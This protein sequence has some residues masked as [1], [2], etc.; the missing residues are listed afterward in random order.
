MS[1]DLKQTEPVWDELDRRVW[2]RVNAPANMWYFFQALQQE[3]GGGGKGEGI[4]AQAIHK[5]IQ[6]M[7]KWCC[8][9]IDSRGVH[10]PY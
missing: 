3:C 10:T 9:V 8:E 6:S 1:P 5:L 4:P 2:G 7:P